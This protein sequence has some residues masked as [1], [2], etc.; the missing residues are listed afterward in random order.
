MVVGVRGGDSGS[1]FYECLDP[2]IEVSRESLG[3]PHYGHILC[4]YYSC[5][6]FY[7]SCI[8]ICWL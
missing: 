7:G 1:R 2:D 6:L 8:A 4:G 3:K 5:L